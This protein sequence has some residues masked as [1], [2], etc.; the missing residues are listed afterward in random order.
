MFTTVWTKLYTIIDS[1]VALIGVYNY[2]VKSSEWGMPLATITPSNSKEDAFQSNANTVEIGYEIAI[3]VKNKD[4]AT[5]EAQIRSIVDSILVL[6]RADYTLTGTALN[7]RREIERGTSND[8]QP[9]RMA[10]IKCFYTL[11]ITI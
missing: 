5:N 7:G 6:L 1:V 2:W 8:E 10:V 11:C 3:Y 9:L 4:I